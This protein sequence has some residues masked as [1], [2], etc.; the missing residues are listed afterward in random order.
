MFPLDIVQYE[1]ITYGTNN[2]ENKQY[3]KISSLNKIFF[4]STSN[5][6]CISSVIFLIPAY[7]LKEIG[8]EQK[9]IGFFL[10]KIDDSG[11][12][13]TANLYKLNGKQYKR[14]VTIKTI[15]YTPYLVFSVRRLLSKNNILKSK[16]YPTEKVSLSN[17]KQDFALSA[18]V[19]HSGGCHYI[20]VFKYRNIWYE[21]DDMGTSKLIKKL[22][23]HD[24]MIKQSKYS[25]ITHGTVYFYIPINDV[26]PPK[27]PPE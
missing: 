14:R 1:A 11:E 27:C 5:Y 3:S 12:L 17:K 9:N 4:P 15:L 6:D 10:N 2:I 18:I 25:P 21:Y 13:N 19:I 23:S 7:K 16:I 26:E 8:D 24:N 22:G 20:C